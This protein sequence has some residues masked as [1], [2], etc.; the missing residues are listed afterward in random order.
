MAKSFLRSALYQFTILFNSSVIKQR[1]NPDSI[2]VIIINFNQLDNLKKLVDFLLE[3]KVENIIIIN[4]K[5]DYTQLLE[6]Y[7]NNQ[8][9][10][11]VEIMNEHCRHIVFFENPDLQ[12]KHRQAYYFITDADILPNPSLPKDFIQTMI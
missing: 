6:Y 12:K 4:N 10:V 3:R 5:S 8:P 2:P 1:R 7:K 11:K 9:K